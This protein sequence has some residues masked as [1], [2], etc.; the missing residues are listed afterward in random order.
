MA[1]RTKKEIEQ[2]TINIKYAPM[3]VTGDTAFKCLNDDWGVVAFD[4]RRAQLEDSSIQFGDKELQHNCIYFLIGRTGLKEMVYVGQAKKR[5]GGGSVLQ[6][7]REHA[8]SQTEQYREIWTRAIV[9]TGKEDTWGPTELNALEHIFYNEIPLE[10]NLN[11]N[12]PNAGLDELE[13][14]SEKV[15]QIELYLALLRVEIFSGT[16]DS[17][18]VTVQSVTNEYSRREDLLNGMARIPEIVTPHKTVVEMVDLLPSD[19]W[20]PETTFLDPAC[21]GGEFLR[22]IYNRLMEA[23]SLKALYPNNIARSNHILSYQIY[24]ISISE[25][26]KKRTT[27][28]LNGFGY[29]IKI[30]PGYTD[31]IKGKCLG[32]KEDGSEKTMQDIIGEEFGKVMKFDVVIGNPPYQ[33]SNGGGGNT[34][35][36]K[37]IYQLFVNYGFRLSNRFVCMITKNSWYKSRDTAGNVGFNLMKKQLLHQGALVKVVDFPKYHEV[38]KGVG[39]S[40]SYFLADKTKSS[41][42]YNFVSIIDGQ[43]ISNFIAK[44]MTPD[45]LRDKELASIAIKTISSRNLSTFTKAKLAFGIDTTGV[46]NSSIIKTHDYGIR[47]IGNNIDTYIS[48][49]DVTKNEDLICKYKIICARAVSAWSGKSENVITSIRLLNPFEICTGT[50]SVVYYTE[51]LTEAINA[52]KYL[53]TRFAREL[54]RCTIDARGVVNG[55]TFEYVPIQDFTSSSD[56]DWSQSVVNIDNQLYRKYDLTQEEINYIEKTIKPM[57]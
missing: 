11:G 34:D 4:I 56:I 51:S 3:N 53:K 27:D 1:K 21:K 42:E 12:N 37:A 43:V 29:N 19:V 54:L 14:F 18:R 41:K 15:K 30:I 52:V 57:E 33:D 40:V 7:L 35:S 32:S 20:N 48:V 16:D 45:L 8:K 2:G 49:N 22:E 36:G 46:P 44:S 9:V 38:F 24:G 17:Q 47:L 31:K 39:C 6:R 5:N 28:N 55:I 23:E 50:Y 26:S 10:N 25:V 13:Q